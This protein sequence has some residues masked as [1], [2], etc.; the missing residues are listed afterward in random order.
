MVTG[1]RQ[2]LTPTGF[3]LGTKEIGELADP[4]AIQVPQGTKVVKV[5]PN[6]VGRY[7]IINILKGF[8]S[9]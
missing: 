7:N 4:I 9:Y 3:T 2:K 1:A 5:R 6:I 8:S